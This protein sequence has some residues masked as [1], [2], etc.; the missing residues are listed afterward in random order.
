M[1]SVNKGSGCEMYSVDTDWGE[2]WIVSRVKAGD[3]KGQ[4]PG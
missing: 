1:D 4:Y 3:E 2:K